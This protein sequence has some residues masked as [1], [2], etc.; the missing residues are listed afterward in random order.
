MLRPVC[1]VLRQVEKEGGLTAGSPR[2]ARRSFRRIRGLRFRDFPGFCG[3]ST[4]R[5]DEQRHR[6][7]SR[8]EAVRQ[9]R[10]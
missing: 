10:P 3:L 5:A 6:H 2:K 7:A 8:S 1:T 4:Q 9:L